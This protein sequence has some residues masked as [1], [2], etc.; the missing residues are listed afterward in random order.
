MA[1]RVLGAGLLILD[2]TTEPEP[3]EFSMAP[4][5]DTLDGKVLG[6]MDNGKAN[7]GK[8]LDLFAEELTKRCKLAGVVRK[9]KSDPSKPAP[10]AMLDELA[11]K[12]QIVVAGIGD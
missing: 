7:A 3:V 9:R 5:P 8:I 10:Q 12:C 1:D 2:P 11:E 4:R 6:L